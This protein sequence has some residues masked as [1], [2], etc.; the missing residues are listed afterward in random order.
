[1][2]LTAR[3]GS[4]PLER[5]EKPCTAGLFALGPGA[6]ALP[7][8]EARRFAGAP[9]LRPPRLEDDFRFGQFALLGPHAFLP[10]PATPM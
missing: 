4:S 10:A 7:R 5:M 6:E 1:V 2:G 3:G 8:R 9:S